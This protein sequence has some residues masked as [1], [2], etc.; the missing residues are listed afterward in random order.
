MKRGM[1]KYRIVYDE[2]FLESTLHNSGEGAETIDILKEKGYY[3]LIYDKTLSRY[4][5]EAKI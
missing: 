1:A 4:F 2:W 5:A 3:L